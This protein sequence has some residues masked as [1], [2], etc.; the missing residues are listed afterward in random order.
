MVTSF[1]VNTSMPNLAKHDLR[2]VIR[3]SS[4]YGVWCSMICRI[5]DRVLRAVCPSTKTEL[6][7]FK[8]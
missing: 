3:M 6:N 2:S 5:L 7:V 8:N 1:D 4:P